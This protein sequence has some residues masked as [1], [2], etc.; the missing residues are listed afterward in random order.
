MSYTRVNYED[1]TPVSGAM[2]QLSEPLES[3][4]VGVSIARC[5]PGWRNQPHDHADNEHEEVYILIEGAATVVVDDEHVEMESGDAIRIPPDA[6]RQIRNG[7]VES[8]FVL[9]SAP[10]SRCVTTAQTDGEAAQWD[11]DGFVG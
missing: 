3:N 9:V 4:E 11:A 5:D 8:A 1:I 7:E 6:T 10:A 2:H